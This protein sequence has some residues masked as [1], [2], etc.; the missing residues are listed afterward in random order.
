MELELHRG[1]GWSLSHFI[2]LHCGI[3][4]NNKKL[5]ICHFSQ[6]TTYSIFM[7]SEKEDLQ[8]ISINFHIKGATSREQLI[9]IKKV[10][11]FI[12]FHKTYVNQ[13]SKHHRALWSVIAVKLD[14]TSA[15]PARAPSA[16]HGG[17]N[18]SCAACSSRRGAHTFAGPSG[19]TFGEDERNFETSLSAANAALQVIGLAAI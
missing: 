16:W 4:H 2:L 5:N 15:L 19:N 6:K 14:P 8:A 11:K 18:V 17:R 12:F 7:G 3:Y 9:H 10:S 1:K 13:E